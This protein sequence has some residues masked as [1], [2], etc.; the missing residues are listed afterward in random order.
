MRWWLLLL[1]LCRGGKR[2]KRNKTIMAEKLGGGEGW[3][4]SKFGLQ[5]LHA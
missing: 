3:F 4:F 5:F 1:L 2:G